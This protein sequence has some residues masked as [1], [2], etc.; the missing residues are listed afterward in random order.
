MNVLYIKRDKPSDSLVKTIYHHI[1]DHLYF[2]DQDGFF[3]SA[4]HSMVNITEV[5]LKDVLKYKPSVNYDWVLINWKQSSYTTD[6][7]RGQAI[8]RALVNYP[9]SR[10]A[11]F[12]GAAQAEYLPPVE[13]LDAMTLIFK[14]E[15]FRNRDL[16]NLTET[17][18]IKIVPTMISCPFVHSPG[19]NILARIYS[20][21]HPTVSIC[22][23]NETCFEV[24]FSGADAAGHTI[25]QDVWARVKAE[26]FSTVGGLQPNPYTKA[27]IP[28]ELAAP[29]FKVKDYRDSLCQAKINLALDGIGQYTFRH[30]ELLYLGAFMMSGPSIRDLDLIIPLEEN[31]HYVAFNDLDDMV[32][33]IRYYLAHKDERQKI[34]LAGKKLFDEYYNPKLHGQTLLARLNKL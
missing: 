7:D 32:E 26:G 23:I 22:H 14:R 1:Q 2:H 18:R 24:G 28:S 21:L 9:I 12:I 3:E 34:A 25:R 11:I 30:Q 33:K 29:R 16:Y 10:K 5:S 27:P 15:P 4:L 17:N 13:V 6:N 31:V 19:E 8:L 20:Y